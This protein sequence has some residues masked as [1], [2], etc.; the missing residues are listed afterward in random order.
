M[1]IPFHPRTTDISEKEIEAADHAAIDAV[2]YEEEEEYYE[3]DAESEAEEENYVS[4]AVN[5]STSYV[6][7]CLYLLSSSD[8][9]MK[10][11]RGFNHLLSELGEAELLE[12]KWRQLSVVQKQLVLYTLLSL[13]LETEMNGRSEQGNEALAQICG[14]VEGNSDANKSELED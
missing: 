5:L 1:C 6:S 13:D 4:D 14:I 3:S 7:V 8:Y 12:D 10:A 2:D 9:E 11:L